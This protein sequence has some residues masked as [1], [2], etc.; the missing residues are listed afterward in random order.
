[1]LQL[2]RHF[3]NSA[4]ASLSITKASGAKSA[5][6]AESAGEWRTWVGGRKAAAIG[7]I[8]KRW[9]DRLFCLLEHLYEIFGL[10][11]ILKSEECMGNALKTIYGWINRIEKAY[12]KVST[13]GTSNAMDV[14]F[15]VLRVVVVDHIP[16]TQ[17]ISQ[18]DWRIVVL[19]DVRDIQSTRCHISG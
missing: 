8:S 12:Q 18:F 19:L 7:E 9:R 3:R 15:R 6:C 5:S 14:I 16:A 10:R 2:T 1:M 11:R 4:V 13:R 17:N